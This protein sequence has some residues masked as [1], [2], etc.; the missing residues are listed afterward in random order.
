[1]SGCL[2][3][4]TDPAEAVLLLVEGEGEVHYGVGVGGDGLEFGVAHEDDAGLAEPEGVRTR[5]GDEFS[6]IDVLG[7]TVGH[8]GLRVGLRVCRPDESQ[9][10]RSGEERWSEHLGP[11]S[12]M[13]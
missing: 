9:G 2:G 8:G 1:M 11:P 5:V 13:G 12:E 6:G 4:L 7:R 3:L 10:E